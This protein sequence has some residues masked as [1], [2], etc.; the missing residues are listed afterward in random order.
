ML[1]KLLMLAAALVT[2]T[3]AAYAED[4]KQ[5]SEAIADK[6]VKAYNS[7]APQGVAAL[8]TKEAPFIGPP[9][10]LKGPA[11]IEKAIAARIKAGWTSETLKINEAHP[12]GDGVWSVGEFQFNGSGE[13]AG[14]TQSGNFGWV[15][16]KDGADW[17]VHMLVAAPSAAPPP[18]K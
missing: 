8:F 2:L 3:G 7:N 17:H 10:V 5:V 15:L 16:V 4:A 13:Q 9:G 14:K 1:R 6:W 18:P 12:L 11:N